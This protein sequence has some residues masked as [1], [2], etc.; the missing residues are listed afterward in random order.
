MLQHNLKRGPDGA[1]LC[2]NCGH[3]QF[4]GDRSGGVKRVVAGWR[5]WAWPYA[6]QVRCR[7]CEE[8]TAELCIAADIVADSTAIPVL[9][10]TVPDFVGLLNTLLF[11][12]VVAV[13]IWASVTFGRDDGFDLSD[14]IA[15]MRA[16][17]V[18]AS[19]KAELLSVWS[20][21]KL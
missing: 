15:Q 2:G 18:G 8:A 6:L 13:V 20:E 3:G 10:R 16:D 4:L 9:T 19:L 11:L 17:D 1:Y 7:N 5:W 14:N 12:G 21:E